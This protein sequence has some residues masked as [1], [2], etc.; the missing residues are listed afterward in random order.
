MPSPFISGSSSLN[1]KPTD[2]RTA[3]TKAK[4][5]VRRRGR[6]R[7]DMSDE[8]FEREALTDS[9]N[10]QLTS[11]TDSDSEKEGPPGNSSA[12]DD[13]F[14]A[15][16][17]EFVRSSAPSPTH[18]SAVNGHKPTIPPSTNWSDMVT[19]DETEAKSL[20]VVDFNDLGKLA[21]DPNV[22]TQDSPSTSTLTPAQ[23]K[24]AKQKAKRK[25]KKEKLK[26]LPSAAVA[27]PGPSSA[28][29]EDVKNLPSEE[30]PVSPPSVT[31]SQPPAAPSQHPPRHS[32]PNP[33]QAYL[34]RLTNDPS[35]VPR[36]GAFWGHDDRL[37]D[38]ELR[39]MSPWWRGRGR[40][41]RGRGGTYT[42]TSR[43]PGFSGRDGF[44]SR[45]RGFGPRP[46]QNSRS[47]ANP[48][49]GSSA[50]SRE[51][52]MSRVPQDY[53]NNALAP[54][55]SSRG[56]WSEA[57]GRG[58]ARGR[59]TTRGGG[60]AGAPVPRVRDSSSAPQPTEQDQAGT[61]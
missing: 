57:R 30:V 49:P 34:E 61:N 56:H 28:P 58:G 27:A 36:V 3:V 8:E 40:G 31:E 17:L 54:S 29:E 53:T 13:A 20:P 47:D 14:S 15:R 52:S 9:S 4:R 33:R 43:D 35:Y 38:K 51:A 21:A 59:G 37:M 32:K 11:D 18:K 23:L 55:P 50:H 41:G 45:G 24:A 25:A 16:K 46:H 1:A 39:S 60:R 10:S 44:G 19:A 48:L 5:L 6:G 22:A 7:G 26:A 12:N 2:S 42:P